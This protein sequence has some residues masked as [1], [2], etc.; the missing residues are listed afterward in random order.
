LGS[1][2][3]QRTF[4][5]LGSRNYRLYW[6][7][8]SIS[9]IGTWMQ[10]TAQGWLILQ[11]TDSAF[12]LG[13][14]SAVGTLPVLLLSLFGGAVADRI[15]KRKLLFVTQTVLALEAVTLGILAWTGVVQ[16]WHVIVLAFLLGTMNAFDTPTRQS[17]IIE[18]VG[19]NQLLNAIG[20][21]SISFNLARILGPAI[22][23]VLIAWTGVAGCFLING[24]SY[25]ATIL[26]LLLMRIPSRLSA[27]SQANLLDSVRQ[28]IR[29][30]RREP[31]I[32]SL[33]LI[34]MTT[35]IFA[36]SYLPLLPLFARDIL[37]TGAAGY[38]GLM[39]AVGIGALVGAF[40]IAIQGSSRKKGLFVFLGNLLFS[41]ALVGLALSRWYWLSLLILPLAGWAMVTQ[42]VTVNTLLQI[43]APD[44][45]RGRVMSFY[46]ITF[47]GMT[48]FGNFL[49]GSIAQLLGAPLAVMIGAF[50]NGLIVS[51]IGWRRPQLRR[52]D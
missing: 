32:R 15:P 29:Y 16:V 37:H 10:A 48:P 24:F 44:S 31:D 38:G 2:F 9:L 5:S 26:A 18:L 17:F 8:Q 40:S 22:A 41:L 20:L 21:N 46:T 27:P 52:L 23:G 47:M 33:L 43:A 12:Y 42:N 50:L 35:S 6:T 19:K 13:L 45:M 3:F 30:V 36:V 4:R 25:C 39:S 7:G 11:L 14:V 51:V 28:G 49:A 1:G 34:V